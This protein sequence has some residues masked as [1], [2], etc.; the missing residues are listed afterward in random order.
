MIY[1]AEH[2][3]CAARSR[4]GAALTSWRDDPRSS[5][6]AAATMVADIDND[7]IVEIHDFG[8]A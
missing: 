3:T 2:V 8:D 7:H 6:S 4:L 5:G 1:R